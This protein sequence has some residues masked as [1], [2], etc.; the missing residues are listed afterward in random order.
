[1]MTDVFT[2][3]QLGWKNLWKE[4]TLWL[5]SALLFVEPLVRLVFPI[6][7]VPTFLPSLLNL[8]ASFIFLALAYISFIGT[9][10][11]AYSIAADTPVSVQETFQA[12]KK[13]FWRVIASSCLFSLFF[14]V[15]IVLCVLLVFVFYFKRPLH[16]LDFSRYF[17]LISMLLSVFIAPWYFLVAEVVVNNSKIG[18]SMENAWDLFIENFAV[19]VVIGVVLSIIWYVVNII[20]STAAILIQYNFDFTALS[21]L[22]FINPHL[23][24]L[25][26]K[27]YV[28]VI[29]VAGAAWRTYNTS[30]FMVAYLKYRSSKNDKHNTLEANTT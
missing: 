19:L 8:V 10:Y 28:L 18:K 17:F 11:V 29:T 12:S 24:F 27:L 21:K 7:K 1:M 15:F 20:I 25:G 22:N 30:I 6:Q 13:F 5:F 3:F 14:I 9:T 16:L 23:S 4:K 26:N 2:F